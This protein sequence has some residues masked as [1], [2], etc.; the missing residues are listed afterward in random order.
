MEGSKF[1]V[2]SS[3]TNSADKLSWDWVLENVDDMIEYGCYKPPG[4][5]SDQYLA[6]VVPYRDRE[7][8]LKIFLWHL[9]NFLKRQARSYCIIVAEQY[10]HAMV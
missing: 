7:D 8:N 4:C 6:V 1:K 9:H 5:I 2:T 3:V 10:D